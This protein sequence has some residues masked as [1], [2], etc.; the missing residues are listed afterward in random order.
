MAHIT[1]QRYAIPS[2]QGGTDTFRVLFA[3][4]SPGTPKKLFV[5]CHGGG[6]TADSFTLLLQ[7]L[8]AHYATDSEVVHA[9]AYD[10]RAHGDPILLFWSKSQSLNALC[11]AK[12]N[13]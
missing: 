11:R 2:V 3:A 5:F 4:P 6:Y 13:E 1:E 7:R 12:S 8:A 9:I 10:A